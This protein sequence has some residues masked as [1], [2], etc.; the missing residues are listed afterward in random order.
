MIELEISAAS[1]VGCVRANNEDMI[2]VGD[3]FIR[4]DE[5]HTLV[6]L[7]DKDRCMMAIADGMGGHNSGDVASSLSLHNLQFFF[8]DIPYG[9]NA[10]EFNETIIGWLDS[11]NHILESKGLVDNSMKGMGTTLVAFAYYDGD[12]YSLN[13]GDSRLYR[14]RDGQLSQL[15]TDH[16]LDNM[17]G[18]AKHTSVITN[19]IGGGCKTSFFD[20]VQMTNDIR[21]GDVYLLCS[22]GLTDMLSDHRISVLL[23]NGD[24]ANQLCEAAIERGGLD[25][26]SACRIDVKLIL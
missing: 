23:G 6:E 26:V 24:D 14:F 1:R 17:M 15:S 13:C 12:F 16:S 4:N 21:R 10:S 18:T 3:S 9:M 20:I 2:L 22:D 5:L 11:V 19:C 8:N 7:K 25:N